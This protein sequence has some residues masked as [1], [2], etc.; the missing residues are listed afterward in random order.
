MNFCRCLF[1]CFFMFSC[2]G[3]LK[4]VLKWFELTAGNYRYLF[5]V[6]KM[7]VNVSL[8]LSLATFV[9]QDLK[10]FVRFV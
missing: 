9:V 7:S 6:H 3:R 5:Q 10:K 2:N 8:L 4:Q 1:H